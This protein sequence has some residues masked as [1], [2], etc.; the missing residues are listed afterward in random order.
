MQTE[1]IFVAGSRLSGNG[2]KIFEP[3]VGV[4]CYQWIVSRCNFQSQ[5]FLAVSVYL[6]FVFIAIG[7][8]DYF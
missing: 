3:E 1:L 2:E 4:N 6:K 7:V 5:K 8:Q